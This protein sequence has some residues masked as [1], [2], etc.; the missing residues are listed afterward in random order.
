MISLA[1]VCYPE[2]SQRHRNRLCA[3]C[4]NCESP[5]EATW[6]GGGILCVDL[7]QGDVRGHHGDYWL[8]HRVSS[9]LHWIP[10][11]HVSSLGRS[12]RGPAPDCRGVCHGCV[13]RLA[14][15]HACGATGPFLLVHGG[16][17]SLWVAVHY[18][19]AS[20]CRLLHRL[21][22]ECAVL[23]MSYSRVLKPSPPV[24]H[25]PIRPQAATLPISI[26]TAVGSGQVEENT[27]NTILPMGATINMDGAAIGYPC[28][29]SFM[30]HAARLEKKLTIATW[31]N[32]G[33]GSSLGSAGA[34]PVP[35]AGDFNYHC[36]T[37][38]MWV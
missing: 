28:A 6:C 33:L 25:S 3:G 30:A 8:D 36:M 31:V 14:A 1:G 38:G 35:N 34:A 20:H 16:G 37:V 29:I 12:S 13:D 10:H 23:C 7:L 26:Q 19:T 27:A 21:Q 32:V 24:C 4:G 5:E 11:R 22:R 15:A 17:E 9:Y 2:Y 18:Q